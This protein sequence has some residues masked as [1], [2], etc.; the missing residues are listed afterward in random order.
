MKDNKAKSFQNIFLDNIDMPIN[1]SLSSTPKALKSNSDLIVNKENS[2]A[3]DSHVTKIEEYLNQQYNHAALVHLKN[4]IMK[5]VSK[6]LENFR[7]E[8][9]QNSTGA[10]EII[11]SLTSQIETLQSEVYFLR[12][13]LKERNTLIKSL[14]T[15]YTL[16]IEQKEH[17]T[18]ELKIKSTIDE[19]KSINSKQI[20]KRNAN[21]ASKNSPETNSIDFH[22]TKLAPENNTPESKNHVLLPFPYEDEV[23]CT[24][25]AVSITRIQTT[26][27]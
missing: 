24:H 5:E 27:L 19:K 16:T 11:S 25:S 3:D 1:I 21:M 23:L 17:K 7:R 8:I 12:D 13:E 2:P 9:K 20:I 10:H 15:P 22:V 6:E 18:K 14:I 4:Q 26:T